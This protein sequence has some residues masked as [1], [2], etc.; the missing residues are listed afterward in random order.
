MPDC[1]FLIAHHQVHE[2]NLRQ[3]RNQVEEALKSFS[4]LIRPGACLQRI[5]NVDTKV[6]HEIIRQALVWLTYSTR[7]LDLLELTIALNPELWHSIRDSSES[8]TVQSKMKLLTEIRDAIVESNGGRVPE[9][10]L[11]NSKT[12]PDGSSNPYFA[13]ASERDR[14]LLETCL[15]YMSSV[16]T[17]LADGPVLMQSDL[18]RRLENNP[19]LSYAAYYWM[20]HYCP[21]FSPRVTSFLGSNNMIYLAWS[22]LYDAREY[23][24]AYQEIETENPPDE[25]K[26]QNPKSFPSGLYY[27]ALFGMTE[28]VNLLLEKNYDV[29]VNRAGGYYRFPLHAA[30]RGG[31]KEVI[32]SLLR[33]GANRE[34]LDQHGRTAME[35]A[36]L[37]GHTTVAAILSPGRM[38]IDRMQANDHE[39]NCEIKLWR[40]LVDKYPK[41]EEILDHLDRAYLKKSDMELTVA[42]WKDVVLN[43]PNS[44]VAIRKLREAYVMNNNCDAAISGW[45]QLYEANMPHTSILKELRD[46]F[47]WKYHSH[48]KRSLLQFFFYCLLVLVARKLI[49]WGAERVDWSPFATEEEIQR[50]LP[51]TMQHVNTEGACFRFWD[52]QLTIFR[53]QIRN[54]KAIRRITC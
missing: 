30:A 18:D 44:K 15:S 37:Y 45:W 31:H 42:G 48:V 12:L 7:P 50:L 6:D 21:E 34:L 46:S 14:I 27:A 54:G 32:N 43:H 10:E 33:R 52:L 38:V 53:H 51:Y 41:D 28:V 23:P 29:D 35:V 26:L 19:F 25:I 40:S 17:P 49:E 16:S 4:D 36:A 47:E 8:E 11:V 24:P 13:D 1:S 9:L 39:A 3:S 2:L 22:Q 20:T 5:E